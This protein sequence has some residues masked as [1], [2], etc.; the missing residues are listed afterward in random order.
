MGSIRGWR[1][2]RPKGRSGPR[3]GQPPRCDVL[4]GAGAVSGSGLVSSPGGWRA[5]GAVGVRYG[6]TSHAAGYGA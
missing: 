5:G 2:R 6:L 3:Y 1:V 4:P